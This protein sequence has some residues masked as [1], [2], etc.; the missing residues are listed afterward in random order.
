MKSS[1]IAKFQIGKN[2]LTPGVVE[3]LKNALK[4]H[5]QVRV[6]VLKST[7]R[8]QEMMQKIVEEL[9]K[10]LPSTARFRVIGFTIVIFKRSPKTA[11]KL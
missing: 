6:S 8:N 1:P 9:Q 10:A 5:T 2:G 11:Q 3:S 4:N 7:G